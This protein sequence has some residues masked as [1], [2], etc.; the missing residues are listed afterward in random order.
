MVEQIFEQQNGY[1]HA[2]VIF[3]RLELG[4]LVI[5]ATRVFRPEPYSVRSGYIV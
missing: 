1:Y 4:C 5:L 2:C 3:M